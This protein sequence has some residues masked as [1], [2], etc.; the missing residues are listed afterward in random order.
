MDY[1]TSYQDE[2]GTLKPRGELLLRGPMIFNGYLKD[3]KRTDEVLIEDN[4]F[5]TG[6]IVELQPQGSIKIIDRRK[7]IFKLA[8]GEYIAPEK[9]ENIYQQCNLIK[10]I[11]VYGESY[12]SFLIS[13]VF[14]DNEYIKLLAEKLNLIGD[15]DDLIKNAKIIEFVQKEID[16]IGK[17][18]GLFGF[19]MIKKI[20]LISQS[21]GTKNLL[22]QTYK[23]KRN[24]AKQY[25]KDIIET[26]Y[27]VQ[28]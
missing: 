8:H 25:F 5:K 17:K 9:L 23:I 28:D 2:E 18:N 13:I 19:E 15:F 21:M 16:E 3:Q 22:T 14:P 11:F 20:H 24:L 7:N 26:L 12:Q 27:D 6:D 1:L 4:W 10:E